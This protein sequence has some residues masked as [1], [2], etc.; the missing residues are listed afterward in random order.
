MSTQTSQDTAARADFR[1]V[2]AW[3]NGEFMTGATLEL[4]QGDTVVGTE[5]F[6]A[7]SEDPGPTATEMAIS[8]GVAWV[9][10][11][12]YTIEE[13]L[14]AFGMEWEREQDERRGW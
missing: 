12:E 6:V 2:D 14:G 8:S 3:D 9:E 10:S 4:L 1:I 7:S 13:R 11:Q 5:T